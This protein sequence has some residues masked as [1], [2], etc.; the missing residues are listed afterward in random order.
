M[1]IDTRDVQGREVKQNLVTGWKWGNSEDKGTTKNNPQVSGFNYAGQFCQNVWRYDNEFQKCCI[2]NVREACKGNYLSWLHGAGSPERGPESWAWRQ[3]LMPKVWMQSHPW[4]ARRDENPD[5]IPRDQYRNV[6]SLSCT[7]RLQERELFLGAGPSDL[8]TQLSWGSQ[9]M[10]PELVHPFI[11][12]LL[13]SQTPHGAP[14]HVLKTPKLQTS[15]Q[16]VAFK[17][18]FIK[19]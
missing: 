2:C 1:G 15:L 14:E 13:L 17:I 6:P 11:Q 16:S 10:K 3:W 18:H 12:H 7:R 4:W 19:Q 8:L 5:R 9:H